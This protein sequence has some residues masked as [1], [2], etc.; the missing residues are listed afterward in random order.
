MT[1][2]K[3]EKREENLKLAISR[4]SGEMK[5]I[6]ERKLLEL[7]KMAENASVK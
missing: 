5:A 6:W 2:E 1:K 7:K 4:T 3:L